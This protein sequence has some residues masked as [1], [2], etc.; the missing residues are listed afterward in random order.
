M[1]KQERVNKITQN[2]AEKPWFTAKSDSPVLAGRSP[3]EQKAIRI[4]LM[5]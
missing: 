3:S 2:D 5:S 1:N 4:H